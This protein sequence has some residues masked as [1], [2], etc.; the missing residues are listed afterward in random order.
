MQS[1]CFP[2]RL[3]IS[4]IE[5]DGNSRHYSANRRPMRNPPQSRSFADSDIPNNENCHI[6]IC[7]FDDMLHFNK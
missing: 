1:E 2:F 7:T 5:L 3:E 4:S 6:L